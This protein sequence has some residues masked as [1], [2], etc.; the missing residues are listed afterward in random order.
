MQAGDHFSTAKEAG[1]MLCPCC[2]SISEKEHDICP[3]CGSNISIRSKSSIQKTLAW[4]ITSVILYIPANVL[5]V[6]TTQT[7]T[8]DSSNT[9]ASGI[10]DLWA[11]GS[12]LIAAVIF[13]ASLIVPIGKILIL[14]Y[15]CLCII[16]KDA[17]TLKTKTRAFEITEALG[18]W[19][20]IDVFVVLTL[21]SLV[22][23][24][25]IASIQSN[26]GILAFAGVVIATMMAARSF[27]IRLLWDSATEPSIQPCHPKKPS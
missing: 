17:I 11:H 16:R 5:P 26:P 25:H 8:Y 13:F 4:L 20:M 7:L 12:Y 24:G 2:H 22:Q 10:I 23:L 18:K 21:V 6:M 9:I 27:D 19:S 15:L 14:G 3:V 1:L